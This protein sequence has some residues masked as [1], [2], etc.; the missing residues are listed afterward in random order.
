MSDR[1]YRQR[2]YQDD[3]RD[4]K[5]KPSAPKK[6]SEPGAPAGARRISQD[7]PKNINMPGYREVVRC[8]QCGNPVSTEIGF[9]NR[10]PRCGT[11][12]HA[13]A[14]CASFDPGSRFECMQ[15]ITA[16][17]SPKNARN[18]CTLFAARTTV[19][20]E[21]TA[22]RTDDARKAFDDLFKF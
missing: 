2:G 3:D 12:L 8:A 11:D 18:S 20:R 22:P 21:T 4:R 6:P 7:G 10:C 16:R 19:E 17:I 13:C 14:Q 5:P 15:P 1:K 9:D